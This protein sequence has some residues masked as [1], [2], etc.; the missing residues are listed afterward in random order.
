ME[1]RTVGGTVCDSLTRLQVHQQAEAGIALVEVRSMVMDPF[2]D[3][4]PR[5]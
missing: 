4:L 1:V 3:E 2:G 5:E